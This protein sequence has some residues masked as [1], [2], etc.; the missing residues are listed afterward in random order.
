MVASKVCQSNQ[1]TQFWGQEERI[2]EKKQQFHVF[3]IQFN[4]IEFRWAIFS[5]VL[6]YV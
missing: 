4:L 6:A 2:V 3:L 1:A 5:Y